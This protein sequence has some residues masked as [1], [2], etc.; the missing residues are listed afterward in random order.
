[1]TSKDAFAGSKAEALLE[2]HVAWLVARWD[3]EGL[4]D[5]VGRRLDAALA[6]ADQLKLE[7]V[8]TLRSIQQT[9][10]GYASDMT[11]GGAIPALVG[12]IATALYEHPVHE[13]TRLEQLMP[14]KQFEE[15]LDKVLELRELREAVVHES[16]SNPIFANLI[17]E[18]LYSGVRD[19]VATSTKFAGRLPGAKSAMKFG[20]AFVDRARPELG[21]SLEDGIKTYV[22][23]NTQ[24]S[25]NASER[26]LLDAFESDEFRQVVLDLWDEN[27]H[28]SVASVRD[29]AGQLDIEELFVIGYEYWQHLRQ[30]PLYQQLIESGIEVFYDT[31]RKTPLTEILEDIGVTR[32]MM[33]RDAMRFLPKIVRALRKKGLLESAIR[34]QL[35]DFYRSDAA[36]AVLNDR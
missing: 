7:D 11:L 17:T 25:L 2:A 10:I 6:V 28:L 15:L 30:T 27:K 21:N 4:E 33:V 13:K 36:A 29:F 14:D 18:L 5:D 12:D 22:N 34:Q 20:K 31:Y 32:D 24:T 23:K 16:V 9:A 26:Y 19:Y 8:V 3:S 35:E 1:M